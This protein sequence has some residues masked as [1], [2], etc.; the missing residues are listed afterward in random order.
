MG[1]VIELRQGSV[2][3]KKQFCECGNSLEYWLGSDN[4][5]Y[6]MC[7]VCNLNNPSEIKIMEFEGE[8]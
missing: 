3:A 1:D 4:C 2:S 6:G 5:G 7:S 8:E